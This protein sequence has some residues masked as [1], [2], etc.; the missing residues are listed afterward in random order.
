[1]AA[2]AVKA[3]Q[4]ENQM[5]LKV[6]NGPFIQ[7]GESL[8]DGLDCSEGVI[9]RLTMPG[10]WTPANITFQIST[11]GAMYNSLVDRDGN[12]ITM[13]VVPG[14]AVVVAQFVPKEALEAIVFLKIRSGSSN[15]P[16]PQQELRE[17]AV[18]IDVEDEPA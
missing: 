17:F 8:S 10:N 2:A 13:T 5:T 18:A 9:T 6:L 4:G 7:E 1:M 3:T 14:S 15:H 12:D 16:V 11:D